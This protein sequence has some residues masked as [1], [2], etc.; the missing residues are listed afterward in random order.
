MT[1]YSC[2]FFTN[3]VTLEFGSLASSK[4]LNVPFSVSTFYVHMDPNI[5]KP[6]G[7]SRTH[8]VVNNSEKCRECGL[9]M[10]QN[11]LKPDKNMAPC[12]ILKECFCVTSS[13]LSRL[14]S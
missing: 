13:S 4:T 11:G 7:V 9:F 10:V 6:R 5:N 14:L 1:I 12:D 2:R 3:Q 8:E